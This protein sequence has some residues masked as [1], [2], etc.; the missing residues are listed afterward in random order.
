MDAKIYIVQIEGFGD[1]SGAIYF[2]TDVPPRL[3]LDVRPYLESN[4]DIM[5]MQ[6]ESD[7]P[8]GG[9]PDLGEFTFAMLDHEGVVADLCR[10]GRLPS[11]YLDSDATNAATSITLESAS[12][13]A[14]N[15]ILWLSGEAI[16][17]TSIASAPTLSVTRAQLNTEAEALYKGLSIYTKNPVTIGRKVTV[18]KIDRHVDALSTDDIVSVGVIDGV[19]T[20][21]GVFEFS[22]RSALHY[23]QRT[24]PASPCILRITKVFERSISWDLVQGTLP[25]QSQ[26]YLYAVKIGNEDRVITLDKYNPTAA[27]VLYGD[28][29]KQGDELKLVVA[30]RPDDSMFVDESNNKMWHVIDIARC[31]LTSAFSAD[32]GLFDDNGDYARLPPGYGAGVPNALIDGDS[33]DDAKTANPAVFLTDFT[34]AVE[35]ETVG[36]I[37]TRILQPIGVYLILDGGTIKLNQPRKHRQ[38]ITVE[39]IKDK[40]CADTK[41]IEPRYWEPSDTSYVTVVTTDGNFEKELRPL[42]LPR[43]SLLKGGT[44]YP[45]EV[46]SQGGLAGWGYQHAFR[47]FVTLAA[48]AMSMR[49]TLLPGKS[50]TVGDTVDVTLQGVADLYAAQR[51]MDAVRMAVTAIEVQDDGDLEVDL[52]RFGSGGVV[53]ELLTALQMTSATGNVATVQ[54]IGTWFEAGDVV[55]YYAPDLATESAGTQIVQSSTLTTVT[56]DGDFSG[57]LSAAASANQILTCVTPIGRTAFTIGDGS[58]FG[59]PE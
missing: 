3:N 17:V 48:S 46:H 31:I 28:P 58:V 39:T 34:Y 51:K 32:D 53:A 4:P 40:D 24:L 54:A 25:T 47:R 27:N 23:I 10:F 29:P 57:T 38:S 52:V 2:G 36:E 44:A 18:Y 6:F 11:Y 15:D 33:F 43:R 12:G 20:R 41:S 8:S 19:S 37:L 7:L 14:V 16:K 45:I 21:A 1:A 26:S 56:L 22:C 55:K 50:L 5:S 59:D 9:A 13:I 49:L 30:S 42:R 35:E